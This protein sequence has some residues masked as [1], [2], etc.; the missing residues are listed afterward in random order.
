MQTNYNWKLS[1]T[2]D[3]RLGL[4]RA[5]TI[6]ETELYYGTASSTG[7]PSPDFGNLVPVTRATNS[8]STV[9]EMRYET[10]AVHNWTLNSRMSL[11]STLLYEIST[12]EQSGTA[13]RSRDFDFI[14]PKLDYRF[15]INKALQLRATAERQVSQLSFSSFTASTNNSDNEKDTEAGNPDLTQEIEMR[16]EL[17]L[18]YRLPNDGGVLSARAFYRDIDD[19]IGKVIVSSD[20]NK[21]VSATGN[22]GNGKRY[23]IYLNASTRLASLGLPDAVLSSSL[24]IWDSRVYDPILGA[25]RRFNGRGYASLNFRHDIPTFGM[26][27]GLDLRME[28][29]GGEKNVEVDSIQSNQNGTRLDAYVSKVA[30]NNITFKLQVDN[31]LGSDGCRERLRFSGLSGSSSLTEV[32]DSCFDGGGRKL[33]LKMKTTF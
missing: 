14:R 23:G 2:Q 27:Y 3:M 29:D 20:P 12:I 8:G 18:E 1:D 4:E 24:N 26:N 16:Y 22:L 10:F 30:F 6:L 31:V 13:S 21:V 9:E 25:E 33:Q 17:G 15:D 11:E 32:E 5:Q 7:T 19:V 28:F